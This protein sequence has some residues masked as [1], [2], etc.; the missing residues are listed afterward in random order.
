MRIVDDKILTKREQQ[1]IM[2]M[3]EGKNK[4]EIADILSLSFS[5]I[6]TNVENI[7][8]KFDVHNKVEL[9]IYVIKKNIIDL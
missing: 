7:Y 6:K 1:I 8:K 4:R 3:L 9:I 2:L 5:T